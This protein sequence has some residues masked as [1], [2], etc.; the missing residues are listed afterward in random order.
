MTELET[1]T[2]ILDALK[3]I[4]LTAC[5]GVGIVWGEIAFRNLILSK[6]ERR[7]W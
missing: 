3:F 2:A 6:N 4:G 7:L 5:L 1:L